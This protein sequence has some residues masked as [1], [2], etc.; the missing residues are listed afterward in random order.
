MAKDSRVFEIM[1]QNCFLNVFLYTFDVWTGLSLS[2]V[3]LNW[4][5]DVTQNSKYYY[6]FEILLKDCIMFYNSK[7]LF[8]K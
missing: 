6:D 5:Y 2:I 3:S 1:F 4:V 7:S 8:V